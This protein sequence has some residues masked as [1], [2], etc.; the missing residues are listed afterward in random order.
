MPRIAA[1][2]LDC[3]AYELVVF[4]HIRI[5]SFDILQLELGLQLRCCYVCYDWIIYV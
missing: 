2:W 4:M 5:F 1:S 3:T